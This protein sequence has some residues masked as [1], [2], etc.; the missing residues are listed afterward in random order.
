MKDWFSSKE[1]RR[2]LVREEGGNGR[3]SFGGI[4]KFT[5]NVKGSRFEDAGICFRGL[6][7]TLPPIANLARISTASSLIR[8]TRLSV[9]G[10]FS[11]SPHAGTRFQS[12]LPMLILISTCFFRVLV[13]ILK[14]PP[15]LL[16]LYAGN[17]F[18]K[19]KFKSSLPGRT[20]VFYYDST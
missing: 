1:L 9:R 12:G 10:V 5:L 15:L 16:L 18:A 19:F 2:R 3:M 13:H 20:N 7:V 6:L 4:I 14:F 11:V 8:L 17:I